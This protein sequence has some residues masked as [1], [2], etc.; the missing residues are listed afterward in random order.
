V[1]D[2]MNANYYCFVMIAMLAVACDPS[3]KAQGSA[4]PGA[5]VQLSQ[6]YETCAASTQCATG[7]R[8]AA[9]ECRAQDSVIIGDYHAAVGHKA[10]AAKDLELAVGAYAEAVNQYKASEREP[11]LW[12]YCD[13]GHVLAAA[14]DNVE[15]AEL[16]ARVLHRCAR[17]APVGSLERKQALADLA[18]LG[19]VGLDPLLLATEAADK[20]LTKAPKMPSADRIKLTVEGAVRT[21]ASSYTDFTAALGTPAMRQRLLPCWETFARDAG[22]ERMTVT[23][24]FKSRYSQGKYEG[25]DGYKLSMYDAAGATAPTVPAAIAAT[26]CAKPM[27]EEVASSFKSRSGSWDGDISLVMAP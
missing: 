14:K 2:A 16:G 12:L 3:A 20:Y 18:I 27:V 17:L 13:Q 22:D 6:E 11:P 24:R 8:C 23:F 25:D 19:D 10:F 4:A 7:L 1:E 9:G 26:A 15:Y 21:S 5:G